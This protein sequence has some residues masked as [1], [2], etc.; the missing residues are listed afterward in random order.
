MAVLLLT[1]RDVQQ[2]MLG[3]DSMAAAIDIIERALVDVAADERERPPTFIPTLESGLVVAN[4]FGTVPSL[5]V[6][7]GAFNPIG[8]PPQPGVPNHRGYKLLYDLETLNLACL[9]EHAPIHPCMVGAHVGVA[10]RWLANDD[11]SSVAVIGTGRLAMTCLQGVRSVR[12]LE[13][14]RVYSPNAEH[15]QNF[16]EEITNDLGFKAEAVDTAEAAVRESDVVVCATNNHFRGG[17]DVFKTEWLTPGTHVNTISRSEADDKSYSELKVF[18]A[19]LQEFL[20]I[21]PAWG[22]LKELIRTGAVSSPSDLAHVVAGS[23]PGRTSHDDITLYIG[24][25]IAAEHVAVAVWVYERARELG[26][27]IEWNQD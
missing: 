5:G 26:L 15:R 23:Q 12:D 9:M 14:A 24:P 16:A 11:A 19:S 8:R 20:S 22:P 6:V 4:M 1:N 3:Q 25:S 13:V 21:E 10:T 2:A 7:G 17:S 27:G 18:P